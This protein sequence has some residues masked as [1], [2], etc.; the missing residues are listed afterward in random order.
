MPRKRR[1]LENISINKA[2]DI[3]NMLLSKMES[4][5]C[6][7]QS[8][9]LNKLIGNKRF[10]WSEE[11]VV[12]RAFATLYAARKHL[13]EDFSW[14]E[15]ALK[16]ARTDFAEL[17][18][19]NRRF[20]LYVREAA[21]VTGLFYINHERYDRAVYA[22]NDCLIGEKDSYK[23]CISFINLARVEI[24]RCDFRRA[25]E[26]LDKVTRIPDRAERVTSF[27]QL[28]RA[29]ILTTLGFYGAAEEVLS[30]HR[31]TNAQDST[32][33]AYLAMMTKVMTSPKLN[34]KSLQTEFFTK[35]TSAGTSP[36]VQRFYKHEFLPFNALEIALTPNKADAF[37]STLKES[38][39]KLSQ[40]EQQFLKLAKAI[41]KLATEK[42]DSNYRV[43]CRFIA[44][45]NIAGNQIFYVAVSYWLSMYFLQNKHYRKA[46]DLL[47]DIAHFNEQ[48]RVGI[49]K[50]IIN[51]LIERG[52]SLDE[53]LVTTRKKLPLEF[54]PMNK[55]WDESLLL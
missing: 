32:E 54:D 7:D 34:T 53:I 12:E 45:T 29:R 28:L 17:A 23:R 44:R 24:A 22:L 11:F 55:N 9:A 33:T 38:D 21:F 43:I 27:E 50:K 13:Y 25:L 14:I 49:S 30:L 5:S 52:S 42:K 18:A 10:S 31:P 2:T 15:K 48:T 16:T 19:K 35:I 26:F 51:K 8:D 39:G 46:S 20:S 37:E 47:A 40:D 3:Q 4:R 1:N 36:S 41:S 6:E